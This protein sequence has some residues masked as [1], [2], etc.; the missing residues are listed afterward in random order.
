MSTPERKILPYTSHHPGEQ[1]EIEFP[2]HPATT[3]AVQIRNLLDALLNTLGQEIRLQGP[4]SDGDLLQALCMALAVRMHQVQAP[5]EAVRALVAEA[6]SQADQAV[7]AAS[8]RSVG[9]A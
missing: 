2:L 7:Q 4:I 1:R 5:A 9:H 8:A 3:N 6:L